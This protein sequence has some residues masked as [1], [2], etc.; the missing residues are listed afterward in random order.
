MSIENTK[1]GTRQR[2]PTSHLKAFFLYPRLVQHIY[3][4]RH[5]CKIVCLF[6]F[7]TPPT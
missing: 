1:L 3:I 2:D 6:P 4:A 7:N 5:F